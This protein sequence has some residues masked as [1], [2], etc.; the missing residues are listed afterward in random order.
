MR[1]LLG[2]IFEAIKMPGLVKPFRYYDSETGQVITI[3][4]SRFYTTLTVG[5]KEFF[6]N[7][8]SGKYDGYGAM[9]SDITALVS[10][11]TADCIPK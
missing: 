7:R 11:C 4:T 6:F 1:Y 5:S 2:K 8:E 3:K 9:A 10:D